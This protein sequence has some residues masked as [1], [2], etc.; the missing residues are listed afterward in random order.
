MTSVESA[1]TVRQRV[2]GRAHLS[3]VRVSPDMDLPDQLQIII[4]D[5]V[6]I[7]ALLSCLCKDHWKMQA[8]NT[9]VEAADK[10]RNII[11]I[12][13]FHAAPLIPRR[14]ERAAAHRADDL[15]VFLVHAGDITFTGQG[16]PVRIHRPGRA[17][18]PGLKNVLK[19]FS[20]SVKV[21]II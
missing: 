4:Q 6:E 8:H 13:R 21:L 18:D 1:L 16:E 20:R 19:L 9:D 2:C 10:H 12:S 5:L 14:K 15:P 17:L 3:K 7:L 11:L